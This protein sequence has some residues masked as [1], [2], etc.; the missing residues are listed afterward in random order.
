MHKK[1]I[2]DIILNLLLRSKLLINLLTLNKLILL[3]YIF[4]QDT[5]YL[6][7]YVNVI[8]RLLELSFKD[9]VQS[10]MRTIFN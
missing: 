8:K 7:L 3:L 9:I 5:N 4:C 1:L 2:F 10:T 6:E